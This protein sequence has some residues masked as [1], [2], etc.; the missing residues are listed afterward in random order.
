MFEHFGQDERVVCDKKLEQH[1]NF[2]QSD[3][4]I[5]HISDS[6]SA[7]CILKDTVLLFITAENRNYFGVIK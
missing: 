1:N 3:F 7:A 2:S 5:S 4:S 6:F